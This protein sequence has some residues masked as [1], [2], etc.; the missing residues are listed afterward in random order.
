[1]SRFIFLTGKCIFQLSEHRVEYMVE[2]AS[3]R[4]KRIAFKSSLDRYFH[5]LIIEFF[6]LA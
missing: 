3:F 2:Y 1:M 4:E 6:S 5:R